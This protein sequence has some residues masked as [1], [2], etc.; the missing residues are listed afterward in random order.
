MGWLIEMSIRCVYI[1]FWRGEKKSQDHY[2]LP[3]GYVNIAMGNH[4]LWWIFPLHMVI[5]HSC[6]K[7]PESTQKTKTHKYL[8][9]YGDFIL[10]N[11]DFMVINADL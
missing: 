9:I 10:N 11:S 4:H 3:S 6:V 1:F 2:D 8:V 5:F 7:L